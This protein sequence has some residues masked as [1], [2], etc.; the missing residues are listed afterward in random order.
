MPLYKTKALFGDNLKL[1][2]PSVHLRGYNDNPV[3]NL[4]S[5]TMQLY[6]GNTAHQ[7]LCEVADTRGHMILGREQSLKMGYVQFPEIKAPDVHYKAETSIKK[8]TAMKEEPVTEPVVPAI[9]QSTDS[10]ITFNGKTHQLPTTKEYLLKEYADVFDGIGTLPGGKYHIQLKDGYKPVQHPPRTV[11]QSLKPAY[12]AELNRLMGLKV[13]AEVRGYTE[14]VNSIVPAK[15]SDGSLRLCLDPK[16]LNKQMKRDKWYS[17]TMDDVLPE[18]AGSKFFSLLDAK[19]GYWHIPLDHESS[20]LTTFNT[21]W[22]KFRWLRRPF[23]LT[24]SGDV[25]QERLDRVLRSIPN[26]TGIADDVLSHGKTAATHDATVI[27]LLETARAN[28]LTFNAKKFVFRSQ[29]CPFFGG[30]LTSGGP[31]EG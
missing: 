22:G 5:I 14:W 28:N 6:Q 19:S 16:D 29:D 3:K 13:I 7:M 17:R 25:F 23:G 9:Q 24:V 21:P 27:T 26:T 30:N 10:S 1:G 11:A 18:L 8:V 15:K 12:R 20:M 4:G 31:Q 2:P